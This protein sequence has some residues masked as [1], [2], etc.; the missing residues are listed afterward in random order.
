MQRVARQRT[1]ELLCALVLIVA[2]SVFVLAPPASTATGTAGPIN[3]TMTP[4]VGLGDAQVVNIHAEAT[5]G[6]ELFEIRAHVCSTGAVTNFVDFGYQGPLCVA[7]GG[8]KEGGLSGDY[9]TF[10]V[11]ENK[12]SG[13]LQFR[14]G[15]GTVGWLDEIG[16]PHTLNCGPGAPC[17]LVV[18]LQTTNATTY[19]AADLCWGGGCPAEPG[20]PPPAAPPAEA[21]P[22]AAP[23]PAANAA[24][25][26]GQAA[27]A[28][29]GAI[30]A[31][32]DA[33]KASDKASS[34]RELDGEAAPASLT[35]DPSEIPRSVRVL[36]A[37]IAGI[38]GGVLIVLIIMRAKRRMAADTA[39]LRVARGV[40]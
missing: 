11:P 5:N 6:A 15:T 7:Q 10:V 31:A 32:A 27:A 16:Y 17:A 35:V 13:D 23:D 28:P 38:A 19:Y 29:A 25:P 20:E 33:A 36:A 4:T 34:T 14:A 1:I 37:E 24:A 8:I 18:Q 22:P 21:A 9:E 39:R 30:P 3:V 40:R 2:G 26:A 12:V